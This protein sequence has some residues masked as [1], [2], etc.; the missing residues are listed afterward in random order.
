MDPRRTLIDRTRLTDE[1]SVMTAEVCTGTL[2]ALSVLNSGTLN[3]N[4][5]VTL[6]DSMPVVTAICNVLRVPCG[7]RQRITVLLTQSVASLLVVLTLHA[8][9]NCTW[10]NVLPATVTLTDPV[11]HAFAKR[12]PLVAGASNES[13][14]VAVPV[15]I[16]DVMIC[17]R[18][19][20]K[21]LD[22]VAVTSVSLVQIVRSLE[23]AP[24]RWE[25]VKRTRP[26]F[27]PLT[28][29]LSFVRA[30]F[31]ALVWKIVGESNEKISDTEPSLWPKVTRN[32]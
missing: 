31:C 20:K 1:T 24:K 11:E 19:D 21:P 2:L 30:M 9:V 7:R 15:F 16:P 8:L 12:I 6:P 23:V 22:I 14:S 17:C 29:T 25:V 5:S 3:D 32:L 26:M 28:V 13:N 4:V 27:N 10:A 18:V